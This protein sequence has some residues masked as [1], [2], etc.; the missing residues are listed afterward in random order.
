MISEVWNDI[1][2]RRTRFL[3]YV[4]HTYVLLQMDDLQSI[5]IRMIYITDHYL[6]NDRQRR[7]YWRRFVIFT[8]E[9]E[10]L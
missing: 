8:K 9:S 6:F 3:Q 7:G 1:V 5:A 4:K 10:Y 2:T